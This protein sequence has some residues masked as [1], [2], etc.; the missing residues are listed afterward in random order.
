MTAI[1]PNALYY[2]ML[3]QEVRFARAVA[4]KAMRLRPFSVWEVLIPIVFILGYMRSRNNRERFVQ[5][6]IFTKKMAL[7][8]VRDMHAKGLSLADASRRIDNQT[9]KLFDIVDKKIYSETIRQAQLVEMELLITH[10]NLLFQAG[11]GSYASRIV[12]AY[13]DATAY[14]NFIHRLNR[15]EKAVA[16]A[17]IQTLGADADKELMARI[18]TSAAT[19]RNQNARKYFSYAK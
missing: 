9:K 13:K 7:E 6:F 17:A 11:P 4:F 15:Q 8:C 16:E 5:N 10:Y 1:H 2:D 14:L 19:L 12:S 3:E 18:E